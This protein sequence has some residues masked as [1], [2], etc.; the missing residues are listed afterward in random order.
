MT[1]RRSEGRGKTG[2]GETGGNDVNTVLVW[3]SQK[4]LKIYTTVSHS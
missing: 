4:N 3:N 2:G 1:L